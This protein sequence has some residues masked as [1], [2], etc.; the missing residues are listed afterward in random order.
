MTAPGCTGNRAPDWHDLS[1]VGDAYANTSITFSACTS[2][3]ATDLAK[4][5]P[6]QIAT[7]SG[8]GTCA[9]DADCPLGYCDTAIS[10]CQ[11]T[12]SGKCTSGA[13]CPANAFCD[14]A[15]SK[16]VFTSQPVYIGGVLGSGNFQSYLRMKIDLAGTIPFTNPPVLHSW[17][18][19][20]L[21]NQV[22]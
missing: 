12:T 8:A 21:C 14:T 3:N 2:Q 18:L 11:V 13:Q 1:W 20:Y 15:S 5:T 4:C 6:Q 7:V 17:D 19:T 10:V 22:L 16:C 9:T